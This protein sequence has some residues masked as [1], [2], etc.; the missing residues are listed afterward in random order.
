MEITWFG[1]SCFLLRSGEVRLL[2]DP[3]D[4]SLGYPPLK[5]KLAV[6]IITVSHSHP[7]HNYT[8]KLKDKSRVIDG[9]GEYEIRG[10]FIDGIRMFHDNEQ[11]SKRGQNTVYV[12]EMDGLILCHLGDLGHSLSPQQ[13]QELSRVEVLMLPVGGVS[14]LNAEMAARVVRLLEPRIVIPMHFK[15]EVTHWLEPVDRFLK[16]MGSRGVAPQSKL[17]ITRSGLPNETQVILLERHS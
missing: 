4:N 11:G 15:T 2:T 13:V 17:S 9:P 5:S 6:N 7:G 1:H 10:V 3:F 8:A 16:E 12:I 14:T